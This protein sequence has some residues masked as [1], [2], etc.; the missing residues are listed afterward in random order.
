MK[1][2]NVILK[3]DHLYNAE[4]GQRIILSDGARMTITVSE[5]DLLDSDPGNYPGKVLSPEEQL[6][7]MEHDPRVKRFKKVLNRGGS[8]YFTINAGIRGRSETEKYECVFRLVLREDLYLVKTDNKV[9]QITNHPCQCE[10]VKVVNC[11][12]PFFEPIHA[13]SLNQ[14]LMKTYVHFF[15]KYGSPTGN[16]FTEFRMIP[17][18]WKTH[19]L[20]VLR[21][22]FAKE[23]ASEEKER[24]TE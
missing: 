18:K 7:K 4:T 5:T 17:E 22:L 3:Y 10:V 16:P 11:E 14:A 8:L 6:R 9:K 20:E 23:L 19:R 2:L 21:N 24:Q 1:A 13:N 15:N 12:L